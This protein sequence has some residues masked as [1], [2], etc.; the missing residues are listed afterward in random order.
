MYVF[1]VVSLL[2]TVAL[3]ALMVLFVCFGI[4]SDS[5]LLGSFFVG[6]LFALV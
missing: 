2:L 3:I 4:V 6:C 1:F 5:C